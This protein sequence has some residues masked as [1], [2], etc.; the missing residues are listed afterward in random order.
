MT[1]GFIIGGGTATMLNIKKDDLMRTNGAKVQFV[2]SDDYPVTVKATDG[3]TK[4]VSYIPEL[5]LSSFDEGTNAI[6]LDENNNAKLGIFTN[7]DTIIS[8]DGWVSSF[9]G[10]LGTGYCSIT[11]PTTKEEIFPITFEFKVNASPTSNI[12]LAG[13]PK[14]YIWAVKLKTTG[15]LS[16]YLGAT[17][18]TTWGIANGVESTEVIELNVPYLVTIDYDG[19]TYTMKVRNMVQEGATDVTFVTVEST[20]LIAGTSTTKWGNYDYMN[21]FHDGSILGQSIKVGTIID[22]SD[23]L[24]Q[25]L[26]GIA[27]HNAANISKITNNYQ[28]EAINP[29]EEVIVHTESSA[30][31]ID[32]DETDKLNLVPFNFSKVNWSDNE[33]VNANT[34]STYAKDGIF[35][36]NSIAEVTYTDGGIATKITTNIIP[37]EAGDSIKSTVAGKIFFYY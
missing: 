6:V 13:T 25:S 31:D 33:K 3:T 36:A 8:T 29:L 9:T 26:L 28:T 16:L 14:Q 7:L 21:Y 34:V 5:D 12:I 37:V 17:G 10:S 23:F 30:K 2:C 20:T 15:T 1:T 22:N 18:N 27:S 4:T 24:K 11:Y 32:Y 35:F 19:A